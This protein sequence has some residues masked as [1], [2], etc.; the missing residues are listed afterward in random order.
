MS[1]SKTSAVGPTSVFPT[2]NIDPY[3]DEFLLNPYPYFE[4]IRSLGPLVRL[5]KYDCLVTADYG[6]VNEALRNHEV[7]CSSAGV[8][9][10]NFH[11][12]KPWRPPSLVLETD[13]PEHTSARQILSK[14]LSL[15][16]LKA[17][18]DKFEAEAERFVGEV[19]TSGSFDAVTDLAEVYPLKVF[20][21]AVGL[22]PEGR[23]NLLP[24]GSMVFNALGP[25]N[26]LF[27]EAFENAKPVQE[28]I[29]YHCRKENLSADGLG[30]QIHRVAEEAGVSEEKACLLVRSVLSAGLDTT[31][32]SLGSAIYCFARY[33]Q[34]WEALTEDVSLARNAFEEVIRFEGTAHS[35]FRTTTQTV[36]IAGMVIPK[37]EKILVCLAGANR[38]PQKWQQ[39]DQFLINRD[40]RGHAGFGIGIHACVGQMVARMEGELVLK[41]LAKQVKTIKLSG[42][43]VR[44]FNNALRGLA[45][46]PVEVELA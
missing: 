9:L 4:E 40:C 42:E 27:E 17:L 43:P 8:G 15:P 39:P 18:R 33:P 46:L 14:V 30:A 10:S 38:D 1:G 7:F 41:A 32:N 19:I 29:L 6:V 13:P 45:S 24:Y 5:E 23:E 25:R 21:D 3:S 2:T 20:P 16:A 35:F 34:Q 12:E 44:R 26:H 37:G 36:T 28:W 11:K 22:P 31:V